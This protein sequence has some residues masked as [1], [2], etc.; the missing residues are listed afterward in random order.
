MKTINRI[1]VSLAGIFCLFPIFSSCVKSQ[2]MST[3]PRSDA[4]DAQQIDTLESSVETPTNII[5]L[6]GDGMGTSQVSAAYFYG[7]EDS[8]PNFSRFPILGLI[9]TTSG[10]DRITDS[11]AGATAFSIGQKS[12]N[13]AIGVDM[14]GEAV[15]TVNELL[16]DQGW[17]SGVISTSGITHATPASFYA[18]V[19][20]RS[21]QYD[22]AT[23]LV[24]SNISFFAGGGQ[25][26]F[27]NRP[28]S[29]NYLD[30]LTHY[31]FSV[32][33]ESLGSAD[34]SK[35]VG[36][37]LAN[38]GLLAKHEGRDDFL[39]NA[40]TEALEYFAQSDKPFFLM[41]EGSQIDWGGHENNGDYVIQ[42]VLDFDKTIGVALDYA[43]KHGNTLVVVTADHE[44]GG[45]SLSGDGKSMSGYGEISPTFSTGGHTATLIPVFAYGPGANYFGG[46]YE[47]TAIFSKFFEALG[48]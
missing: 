23:S 11:G 47:N 24:H 34:H 7:E 25:K 17:Q 27:M 12:Y 41:V 26:W 48:Q 29:L 32:G 21:Q 16:E 40:T 9:N 5:F 36:Y 20:K 6:I 8:Q 22:I 1:F 14:Q 42:E 4:E 43:E 19:A 33:M 15:Q 13:G 30:S 46:V 39:P 35:R 31:G 37:L 2:E 44:T 38:D 18:H 45:F 10:S 3:S 28:D